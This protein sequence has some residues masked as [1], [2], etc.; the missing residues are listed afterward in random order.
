MSS[1][2]RESEPLTPKLEPFEKVSIEGTQRS[3]VDYGNALP[4]CNFEK[5]VEYWEENCF[6][7]S[8]SRGSYQK[9]ILALD[10]FRN[11][12]DLRGSRSPYSGLGDSLLECC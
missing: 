6:G 5:A 12:H 10:D 8:R 11:C 4:S 2:D 1:F 3:D 9:D 7:L